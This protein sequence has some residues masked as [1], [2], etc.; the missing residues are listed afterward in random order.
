MKFINGSFLCFDDILLIPQFSDIRSRKDVDIST[1][2]LNLRIPIISSPMDTITT[3]DMCVAL[4]RRGAIGAM[5]RFY[6][7]IEEYIKDFKNSQYEGSTPIVSVGLNDWDKIEALV[8]SGA[9]K[10]LLDIAHG[11]QI[12]V[13]DFVK[14]FRSQYR[15]EQLIIGNFATGN[16]IETFIERIGSH[17]VDAYRVGIGGGAACTTQIKTGHG[18]PTL[19]SVYETSKLGIN[20]IADGGIKSP[21]DIVKAIACGAKAVMVG[22]LLAGTTETPTEN[23][24]KIYRGSASLDSYKIQGKSSSYITAEG[25]SYV[26]PY[27]GPVDNIISDI[28]GGL[29]SGLTYTGSINLTDFHEKA[30]IAPISGNGAKESQAHGKSRDY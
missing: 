19:S 9:D 8:K 17:K 30:I 28:E 24:K 22:R 11:A 16:Q 5:H 15:N 23:G 25:E 26:V 7:N 14:E 2:L 13:V 10:I 1:S 3:P 29:R 6:P 21:G 4:A 18:L 20:V 12:S 27:A